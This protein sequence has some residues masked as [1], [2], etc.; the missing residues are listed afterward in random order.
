LALQQ[1]VLDRK[2]HAQDTAQDRISHP[3]RAREKHGGVRA[4]RVPGR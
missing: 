4:G 1:K 2:A 3:A